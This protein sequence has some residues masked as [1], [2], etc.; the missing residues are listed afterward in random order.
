MELFLMLSDGYVLC[1]GRKNP[2]GHLAL[3]TVY[4]RCRLVYQYDWRGFLGPKKKTSVLLVFNPLCTEWS[5]RSIRTLCTVRMYGYMEDC[6]D[7]LL[8]AG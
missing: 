8:D 4:C 6:S 3:V 5:A 7:E 1:Q 2:T